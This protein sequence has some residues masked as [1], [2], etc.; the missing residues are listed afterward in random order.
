VKAE[1]QIPS[2]KASFI[3]IATELGFAFKDCTSDEVL[4]SLWL[5]ASKDKLPNGPTHY[6]GL[7]VALL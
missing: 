5:A 3:P 4:L 1:F 6:I 7:I 2:N